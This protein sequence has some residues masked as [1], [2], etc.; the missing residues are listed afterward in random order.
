MHILARRNAVAAVRPEIINI[1]A[2]L[3][4]SVMCHF[5]FGFLSAYISDRAGATEVDVLF[6]IAHFNFS[7][8]RNSY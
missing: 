2:R 5:S 8:L 6:R 7:Y 1:M 4:F 3:R